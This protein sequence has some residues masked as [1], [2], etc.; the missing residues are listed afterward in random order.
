MWPE[1][2]TEREEAQE[3]QEWE[4]G[5]DHTISFA[6]WSKRFDSLPLAVGE[7]EEQDFPGWVKMG[8]W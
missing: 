4:L 2:M 5:P 6:I 1:W 3:R 8:G 7:C